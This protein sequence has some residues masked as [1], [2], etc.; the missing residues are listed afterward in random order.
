[1]KHPPIENRR[2]S[3]FTL[4]HEVRPQAH[5]RRAVRT[6]RGDNAHKRTV[7]THNSASADA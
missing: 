7:G 5:K 2:V 1:M 6:N 4:T 3:H